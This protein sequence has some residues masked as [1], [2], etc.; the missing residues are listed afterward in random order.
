MTVVRPP[1]ASHGHRRPPP[2]S[3]CP[4]VPVVSYLLDATAATPSGPSPPI[5]PRLE[6]P[7]LPVDQGKLLGYSTGLYLMQNE[8]EYR[9]N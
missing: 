4:P 8:Q 9:D 1:P 2:V 6:V 3:L 7:G 5:C